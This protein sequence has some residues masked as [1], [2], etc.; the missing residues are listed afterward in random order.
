MRDA[1]VNSVSRLINGDLENVPQPPALATAEAQPPGRL[2]EG[3]FPV[4]DLG[5][6]ETSIE[7]D[8]LLLRGWGQAS[9]N[10]IFAPNADDEAL[11][12]AHYAGEKSVEVALAAARGDDTVLREHISRAV[13]PAGVWRQ[14]S[15]RLNAW[16]AELGAL[17]SAE[18]LGTAL[19]GRPRCGRT[20]IQ[21]D[22]ERGT[23]L[24]E[25]SWGAGG[26]IYQMIPVEAPPARRF[27]RTHDGLA[28]YDIFTGR[29]NAVALSLTT[30]G[31]ILRIGGERLVR[32]AR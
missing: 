6:I 23:R 28:A 24:M 2:I 19:T 9:M 32:S 27:L 31:W 14:I 12:F 5:R 4:G 11:D 7:G 17:Q 29:T 15:G 21:I 3:V 25:F 20:T 22:Y 13:M 8:A 16:A 26:E 1:V 18:S 30:S 10:Q